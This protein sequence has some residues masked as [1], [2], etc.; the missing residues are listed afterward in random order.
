[1]HKL[2]DAMPR[3]SGESEREIQ[4]NQEM[5][6]NHLED[7]RSFPA[8]KRS[9]KHRCTTQARACN[10]AHA[11]KCSTFSVPQFTKIIS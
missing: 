9:R 4:A 8:V 6:H 10:R 2:M 3:S 5:K 1:M 7:S 11:R